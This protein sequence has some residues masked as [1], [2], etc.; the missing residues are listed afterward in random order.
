M[1]LSTIYTLVDEGGGPEAEVYVVKWL[2]DRLKNS[3]NN[4]KPKFS[5]FQPKKNIYKIS[6]KQSI[7][8]SDLGQFK[9]VTFIF[10]FN[11]TY[12]IWTYLYQFLL[13]SN[14]KETS[15]YLANN[16]RNETTYSILTLYKFIF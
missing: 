2:P 4:K 6:I 12:D 5:T 16:T 15:I 8:I 14:L 1:K 9:L 13:I 7:S 3:K 10:K 11:A